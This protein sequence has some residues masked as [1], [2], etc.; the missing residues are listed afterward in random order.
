MKWRREKTQ[1]E[2]TT[3]V[4]YLERAITWHNF[5]NIEK[6]RKKTQITK[7][8]IKQEKSLPTLER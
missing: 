7:I 6:G 1:G 5:K 4:G 8:N 3:R 2:S